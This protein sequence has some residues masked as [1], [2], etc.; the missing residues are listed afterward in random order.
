MASIK[1]A[2]IMAAGRGQRM[3]PLTMETPKAMA[4]YLGSTLIRHGIARVRE[5]V[6]EVHVTIGY[7]GAM[8]AEHVIEEGVRSIFNTEGHGNAWWV[9]NTA[10][11]FLDEPILVLTCDNVVELDFA[12]L[13]A[14]YDGLG[15]PACMV[16]PVTPVPGIDGDYIFEEDNVVTE[17]SRLKKSPMYCSGIQVL[18]CAAINR[19]TEA[20]EDF[21]HL[22][23]QLI[24]RRQLLASRVY[25]KR[26]S[27]FDTASQLNEINAPAPPPV[28][29]E[30]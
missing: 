2:L 17:L 3:L 14:E 19:L 21:H 9:Y 7:K 15:N 30:Q 11:K 29:C 1:H 12:R 25:P 6:P 24:A 28:K 5:H 27:S 13:E 20:G 18:N 23:R 16:V 8:L 4:P 22:W 26:W 10:L